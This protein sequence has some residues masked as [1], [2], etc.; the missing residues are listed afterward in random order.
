MKRRAFL[1]TALAGGVG[2]LSGCSD[3]LPPGKV[4]PDDPPD[5]VPDSF[6]CERPDVERVPRGYDPAHLGWGRTAGFTLR[7]DSLAVAYGDTVSL[8]LSAGD[9]GNRHLFN[10]ELRTADGWREVRVF[11]EDESYYYTNEAVTK[12]FSWDIEL[13]EAGSRPRAPSRTG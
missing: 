6:A 7:V 4:R 13:T 1:A 2:G 10:L 11:P 3:V 12:G 9:T 8:S 5:N